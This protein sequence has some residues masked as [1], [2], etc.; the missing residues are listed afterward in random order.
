MKASLRGSMSDFLRTTTHASKQLTG[1]VDYGWLDQLELIIP[2]TPE[3]SWSLD[4]S[5]MIL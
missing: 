1:L 5:V 3:L 2:I 4:P